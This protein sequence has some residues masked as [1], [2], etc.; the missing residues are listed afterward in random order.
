MPIVMD[1][2][3]ADPLNELSDQA[4]EA[5]IRRQV[6]DHNKRVMETVR[7]EVDRIER[8]EEPQ[9]RNAIVGITVVVIAFVVLVGAYLCWP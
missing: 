8:T 3:P 9:L 6:E 1:R 7:L 2:Y 5:G 4:T